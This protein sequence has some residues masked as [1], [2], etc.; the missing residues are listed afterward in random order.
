MYDTLYTFLVQLQRLLSVR[1]LISKKV[2]FLSTNL[3]FYLLLDVRS[4][5]NVK[6]T[7]FGYSIL[8]SLTVVYSNHD[9][10]ANRWTKNSKIYRMSSYPG[11]KE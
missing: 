2:L 5:I 8:I 10:D 3:V 6:D 7:C 1:A 11:H 4:S 9:D